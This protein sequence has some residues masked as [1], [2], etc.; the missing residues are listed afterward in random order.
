MMFFSPASLIGL[1]LTVTGLAAYTLSQEK[2]KSVKLGDTVKILCTAQDDQHYI[3]WYR[4]KTGSAP[5]FLLRN[6][7]RASGLPRRF[8]YTDSGTQ[9]YLNING[10]ESQDEAV[11]YCACVSCGSA[12]GAAF[13][14]SAHT[15]I[16]SADFP[17]P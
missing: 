16:Y 5:E 4:Q 11:Y 10:V 14:W 6:N 15:N 7:I 3:S 1:L 12:Y 17:L 2:S 8:T 9:D 13:Q